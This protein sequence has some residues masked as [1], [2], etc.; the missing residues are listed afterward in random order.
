LKGGAEE[1]VAVPVFHAITECNQ[2][3]KNLTLA[4]APGRVQSSITLSIFREFVSELEGRRS[5]S[6]TPISQAFNGCAKSSASPNLQRSFRSFLSHPGIRES[7]ASFAAHSKSFKK[8]LQQILP[9]STPAL[10][11][12]RENTG[13]CSIPT[14]PRTASIGLSG[15]RVK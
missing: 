5:Q 10:F 8:D 7:A 3:Q 2:F 4:A 15:D 9:T 12:E 11:S 13:V 6:R 1:T 14:F